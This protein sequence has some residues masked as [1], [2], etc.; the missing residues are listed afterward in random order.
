MFLIQIINTFFSPKKCLHAHISFRYQAFSITFGTQ[1]G[2]LHFCST[3]TRTHAY[4]YTYTNH[5]EVSGLQYATSI[6]HTYFIITHFHRKTIDFSFFVLVLVHSTSG[7]QIIRHLM[8]NTLNNNI[9][10]H[11]GCVSWISISMLISLLNKWRTHSTPL[12]E[13]TYT[14]GIRSYLGREFLDIIFFLF[15]LYV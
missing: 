13:N 9:R 4:T 8:I 5:F 3:Y 12:D 10:S 2:V 6:K 1:F 11:L 14:F 15:V 7:V